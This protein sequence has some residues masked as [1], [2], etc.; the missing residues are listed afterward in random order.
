MKDFFTKNRNDPKRFW[1]GIREI[2]PK[3]KSQGVLKLTDQATGREL[4]QEE[5]PQYI[6]NY[7]S[8]VGEQL[9]SKLDHAHPEHISGI[10]RLNVDLSEPVVRIVEVAKLIATIDTSK[11]S[12][13][14]DINSVVI[15]DALCCLVEKV[16]FLFNR[17]LGTKTFPE[18]WKKGSLVPV[19]K[20]GN[21]TLVTNLRPITVLPIIGKLYEIILSKRLTTFLEKENVYADQQ[22]GFR[23]VRSTLTAATSLLSKI[24]K[25]AERGLPTQC[26]F[27]DFRKAF[28]SVCHDVLL[29][30]LKRIGLNDATI[31]I[32]KNYL[33]N[34]SIMTT[35][36]GVSSNESRVSFGV[37][38]GSVLGPV[39]F[40]I[41]INDLP[42]CVRHSDIILYADDSTLHNHNLNELQSD[43]NAVTQWCL[44]NKM[45]LNHDKSIYTT[46]FP[47]FA[48][49]TEHENRL[50]I[51]E[52]SLAT[53]N[54]VNYLGIRLD[55]KLS[56]SEHYAYI[57]KTTNLKVKQL[58]KVKKFLNLDAALTVY[59]SCIAPILD[60]GDFLYDCN[61]VTLNNRLQLI[62]NKAFRAI[63]GIR[64]GRNQRL[65]TAE[66]HC[67]AKLYYLNE[68]RAQH[69]LHYAYDLSLD[70]SLLTRHNV[71][72][73][74]Q[75][76][77]RF[78]IPVIRN[79]TLQKIPSIRAMRAWN[80]L[81][82]D[83]TTIVDKKT[84]KLALKHLRPIPGLILG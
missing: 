3:D 72:T 46:F 43:L 44:V 15:K 65:T 31:L 25:N 80:L 42:E 32:F 47:R 70:E 51:D 55:Q 19:P 48:T 71:Q 45:T 40:S 64:L 62:Q 84:F 34:R 77:K 13:L 83:Y 1:E 23:K 33:D 63:Y 18:L 52:H 74:Y 6:N 59:K 37:P 78:N 76:G 58:F 57:R 11:S 41:F 16:T 61:K 2:L 20:K 75:D 26:V 29:D 68:R 54:V 38:Q 82:N 21:S 14:K 60:Y 4:K 53:L 49:N 12:G 67:E 8:T 39:L 22:H 66:L 17:C 36:N 69:L 10:T 27:L 81:P 56:F 35:I 30:K 9:A 5:I 7:F 73:R 50:N 24:Y 79:S 28:D